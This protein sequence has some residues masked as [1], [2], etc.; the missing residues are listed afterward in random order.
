MKRI[1]VDVSFICQVTFVMISCGTSEV[2]PMDCSGVSILNEDIIVPSITSQTCVIVC[3]S[4]SEPRSGSGCFTYQW[5]RHW[6]NHQDASLSCIVEHLIGGGA[7]G[8][9]RLSDFCHCYCQS[10]MDIQFCSVYPDP[11]PLVSHSRTL[12]RALVI[13]PEANTDNLLDHLKKELWQVQSCTSGSESVTA[14]HSFLFNESA[15]M[16][17]QTITLVILMGHL[18]VLDHKPILFVKPSSSPSTMR[19]T[20]SGELPPAALPLS[21]VAD[22][23][24][25]AVN[26]PKLL[27]VNNC[28]L[29]TEAD[30][31]LCSQLIS[32]R[33]NMVVSFSKSQNSSFISCFHDAWM[34][35]DTGSLLDA[36]LRIAPETTS[37][38]L[39]TV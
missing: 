6:K 12:K 11:S 3:P 25:E 15:R 33:I 30:E 35:L 13:S 17:Q 4:S 2:I 9:L 39:F 21:M 19:S 23:M 32:P 28:S 7:F 1:L 5:I 24:A 34:D 16:Q 37:S 18:A 14:L 29:S 22:L 38:C 36:F 26:G 20:I 31:R 10:L 27:A 8:Q